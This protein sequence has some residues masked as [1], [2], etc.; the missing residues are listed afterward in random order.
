MVLH[1]KTESIR[2]LLGELDRASPF[3]KFTYA[4][5][6]SEDMLE[7]LAIALHE[8]DRLNRRVAA[9]ERFPE[10]SL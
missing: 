5:K 8:I 3:V 1:P 4:R 2:A 6:I 7:L 9:L 10:T